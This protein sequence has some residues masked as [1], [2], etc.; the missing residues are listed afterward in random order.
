MIIHV[1]GDLFKTDCDIIA[2]GV[3]CR[4]AFGSGVAARMAK[5]YPKARSQYFMKHESAGWTLGDVQFV[6]VYNHSFVANCA[7]Q[8]GY[9]PRDVLHADYDALRTCMVKVKEF[10][11]LGNW[12]VAAPRIGAGLAG[13]DWSIIEAIIADVFNDYDIK[14]YTL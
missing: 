4:G 6:P 14:V 1:R 9:M 8:D 2:H 10:A 11:K 13:G 12:T 3:N 5:V 7:T